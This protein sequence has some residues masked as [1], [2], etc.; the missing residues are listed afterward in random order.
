MV[1]D[2]DDLL[3]IEESLASAGEWVKQAD[4][5]LIADGEGDAQETAL[6][7]A[8]Q[9]YLERLGLPAAEAHGPELLRQAPRLAWGVWSSSL[10]TSRELR[11]CPTQSLARDCATLA[12]LGGM[13]LTTTTDSRWVRAGWPQDRVLELHGSLRR[14]QCSEPCCEELWDTPGDLGL[15]EDPKTHE[16]VGTLPVCPRCGAVARPYLRMGEDDAAWLGSR[17]SRLPAQ[18]GALQWRLARCSG[19]SAVCLEI[20]GSA[21]QVPEAWEAAER[22]LAAR[23]GRLIRVGREPEALSRHVEDALSQG[24]G[25][26]LPL[27]DLQVLQRCSAVLGTVELASFVII[28]SNHQGVELSM[29]TAMSVERLAWKAC[30]EFHEGVTWDAGQELK[31]IVINTEDNRLQQR[32]QRDESVPR[33][34][35]FSTREDQPRVAILCFTAVYFPGR[36]ARLLDRIHGV[37]C[38]LM[39]LNS[40]FGSKEYQTKLSSVKHQT[41]LRNMI[42][43]VHLVV[44][45]KY[46][47]HLMPETDASATWRLQNKMVH[48]NQICTLV[49]PALHALVTTSFQYSGMDRLPTLP[50][51]FQARAK[52]VE[53]PHKAPPPDSA[54]FRPQHPRLK[55]FFGG[56]FGEERA[57]SAF[58]EAPSEAVVAYL[59]DD[60]DG[61][62]AKRVDAWPTGEQ[63]P[64]NS[65]WH[66]WGFQRD[67]KEFILKADWHAV[68]HLGPTADL[69]VP[70]LAKK[71]SLK[72]APK[73][74]LA[75]AEAFRAANQP[76]WSAMVKALQDLKRAREDQLLKA[77]LAALEA[78]ETALMERSGGD[79]VA[80]II[81]ALVAQRH[82]GVLEAQVWWGEA[83]RKLP[84]HKDGATS[85]L[86]LGLTLGGCRTLRVGTY[87]APDDGFASKTLDEPS[88]WDTAAWLRSG[89]LATGLKDLRMV[90]GC[91]YLSSP[92]CF[93]HGVRYERGSRSDPIIAL[94][95]RV[96]FPPELGRMLNDMRDDLMLAVSGSVA[97]LLKRTSESGELRMPSLEEVIARCP[98]GAH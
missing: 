60:P 75:F 26:R 40:L 4:L 25:L 67:A 65:R 64:A 86:H 84:S 50:T 10:R 12:P 16:A 90:R 36:N 94:Q 19:L 85:L 91:A 11:P 18:Q 46:G 83:P 42:K 35:Y 8:H 21:G 31:A 61:P 34:F 47:F 45:P 37:H 30:D 70:R 88:V 48:S 59:R 24:R 92:Y 89:Q 82:F 51:I 49:E 17:S 77:S 87:P 13:V 15:E 23:H 73:R 74:Y 81:R 39:D 58:L 66:R 5:L 52:R 22:H 53:A 14:L 38:L 41:E 78:G 98:P 72:R 62:F 63:P 29:P 9:E 32:L 1:S 3:E 28:D 20:G 71:G 80:A 56:W 2:L 7:G 57:P 95:C 97:C 68:P 27:R 43:E 44:L 96:A 54:A 93:E 33:E 79:L 6:R 69:F 76:C 55:L